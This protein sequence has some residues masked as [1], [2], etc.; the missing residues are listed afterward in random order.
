LQRFVFLKPVFF[1]F[2]FFHRFHA[3]TLLFHRGFQLVAYLLP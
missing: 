2:N 3:A 1:G